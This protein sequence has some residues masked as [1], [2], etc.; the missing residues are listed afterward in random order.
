MSFSRCRLG[1]LGIFIGARVA[2]HARMVSMQFIR[3][4]WNDC[5]RKGGGRELISLLSDNHIGV[6][7]SGFHQFPFRSPVIILP[8]KEESFDILARKVG[9]SRWGFRW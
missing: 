3:N 5:P 2:P 4:R 1:V 7:G 8:I 9:A 6:G